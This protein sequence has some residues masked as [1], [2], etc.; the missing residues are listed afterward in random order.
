[1]KGIEVARKVVAEKSAY[2][3]R[4][5]KGHEGQYDA[6][7]W[8]G[9]K[10]GWMFVDLFSAST[11]VAVYDAINAED[12]AKLDSF[13]LPKAIAIAFKLLKKNQG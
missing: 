1:M 5:M 2:L 12:Q 6:K 13:E 3:V 9:N 7:P 11:L 8:S 4:P 10:R